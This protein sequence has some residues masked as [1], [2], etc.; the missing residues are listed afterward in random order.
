MIAI[1]QCVLGNFDKPVDP[2]KQ[3]IDTVFHR[4]TDKEFPPITGL[5]PRLQYRIP[6]LF[7]WQMFPGYDYYIW[8]D[9][10]MSFTRPDCAKW[11]MDQLGD[12]DIAFFK[13]PN[14][15]TIKSEIEHIEDHLRKG[16]DYITSRYKNGLHREMYTEIMRSGYIDDRLYASTAFIYK[17]TEATQIFMSAWWTYQSRYYSVDQIAQTFAIKVGEKKGLKVKTINED[18]FKI[19]YLTLVSKH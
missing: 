13:H 6:K 8:L 15:N 12:N 17:N 1:L 16:K 5:T 19:P 3:N 4:F 2:V 9:G 18:L 11:F 7:G 10:S 14:R